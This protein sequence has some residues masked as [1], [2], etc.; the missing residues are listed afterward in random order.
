M[1]LAP[2]SPKFPVW[3]RAGYWTVV[4]WSG[5]TDYARPWRWATPS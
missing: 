1:R 3:W 2:V 5:C 4:W